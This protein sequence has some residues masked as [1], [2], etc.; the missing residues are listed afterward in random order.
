MK[1]KQ[2]K[3]ETKRK[4]GEIKDHGD[5]PMNADNEGRR[6]KPSARGEGQV[7]EKGD[8]RRKDEGT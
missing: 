5:K 7:H 3:N 1:A 8:A 4:T 2:A 6:Q